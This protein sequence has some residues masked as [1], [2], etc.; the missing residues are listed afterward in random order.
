MPGDLPISAL[1]L[2][3]KISSEKC[4]VKRKIPQKLEIARRHVEGLNLPGGI[5]VRENVIT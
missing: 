3:G 2:K 4:C 1:S 5:W